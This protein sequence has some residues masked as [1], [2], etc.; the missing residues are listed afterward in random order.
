MISWRSQVDRSSKSGEMTAKSTS[1]HSPAEPF[2]YEPYRIT[3]STLTAD[4]SRRTKSSILLASST[5][6][7]TIRRTSSSL[8]RAPAP[9]LHYIPRQDTG[10]SQRG[11][12]A[13]S[14]TTF[15]PASVQ[16]PRDR[17]AQPDRVSLAVPRPAPSPQLSGASRL[18]AGR[19]RPHRATAH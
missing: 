6:L 18:P 3:A 16:R 2:A 4:R 1:L 9:Q 10:S 13:S 11:P 5:W 12:R 8:G 14:G 19:N 7:A 17:P 15:A